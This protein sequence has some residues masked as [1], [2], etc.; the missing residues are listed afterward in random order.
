MDDLGVPLF[1][2][3]P[4]SPTF[5]PTEQSSL[6][7]YSDDWGTY[8]SW[9]DF[10]YYWSLG[11]WYESDNWSNIDSEPNQSTNV[12]IVQTYPKFAMNQL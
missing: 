1:S 6:I 8:L 11:T 4:I 12:D 5:V 7:N 3:T 10:T 9:S 2:E